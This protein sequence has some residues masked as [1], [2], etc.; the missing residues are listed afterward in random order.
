MSKIGFIEPPPVKDNRF[1]EFMG[2]FFDLMTNVQDPGD[3]DGTLADLTTK[4]NLLLAAMREQSM[5]K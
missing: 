1:N 5:I 4:F 2:S 3:A